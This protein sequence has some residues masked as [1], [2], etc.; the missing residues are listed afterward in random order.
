MKLAHILDITFANCL[1]ESGLPSNGFVATTLRNGK[2]VTAHALFGICL[3]NLVTPQTRENR[4]IGAH[5]LYP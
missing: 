1:Y 2:S 4:R 3:G 5:F